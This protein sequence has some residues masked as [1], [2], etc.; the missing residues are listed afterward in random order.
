MMLMDRRTLERTLLERL[1]ARLSEQGFRPK[2]KL[3]TNEILRSF[4]GG[5][6]VVHIAAPS[7][8]ASF[9]AVPS[10]GVRHDAVEDLRN[11]DSPLSRAEQ[12]ETATIGAQL[13]TLLGRR[14]EGTW[15][16]GNEQQLDAAV[17]GILAAY[18]KVGR[19]FLERFSSLKEVLAVCSLDDGDAGLLTLDA[20]MCAHVAVAVSFV[21]GDEQAFR[22]L[23]KKSDYLASIGK[24][25][26][27]RRLRTFWEN[28]EKRWAAEAGKRTT[29]AENRPK[30]A[31]KKRD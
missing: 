12:A 1:A 10:F 16:I 23:A 19:P 26:A 11:E 17:E 13:P 3:K 6:H 14:G 24:E 7:Y 18:E 21:L 28:L 27:S 9:V 25:P 8:G 5:H 22:A 20:G 15:E 31:A 4:T 30:A 2:P 29:S